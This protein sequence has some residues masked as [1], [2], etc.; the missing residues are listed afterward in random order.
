MLMQEIIWRKIWNMS[1]IHSTNTFL[2]SNVEKDFDDV[3]IVIFSTTENY[4]KKSL[5]PVGCFLKLLWQ[6]RTFCDKGLNEW[7]H[8]KD[9]CRILI[10]CVTFAAKL[11]HLAE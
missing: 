7:T 9:T 4:I 11:E 2:I 8:E 3:V 6:M 5:D 10:L 1:E